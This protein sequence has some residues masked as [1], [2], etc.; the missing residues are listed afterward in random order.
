MSRVN[1]S[2]FSSLK[3][4]EKDVSTINFKIQRHLEDR[5]L[6]EARS[7]FNTVD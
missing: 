2:R 5:E 3:G 4:K 1:P 6:K 7:K